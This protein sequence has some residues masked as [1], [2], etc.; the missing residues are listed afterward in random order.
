METEW[1]SNIWCQEL[2]DN[3]ALIIEMP[4]ELHNRL[5]DKLSPIP[6]MT[7]KHAKWVCQHFFPVS[8]WKQD[9]TQLIVLCSKV[10]AAKTAK[11]LRNQYKFLCTHLAG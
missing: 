9:L 10:G 8:D 5:H 4:V 3:V 1:D 11:A 6:I 2:R 7:S